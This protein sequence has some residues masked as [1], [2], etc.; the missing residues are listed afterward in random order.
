MARGGWTHSDIAAKFMVG[1]RST[2]IDIDLSQ[3]SIGEDIYDAID[4]EF[5]IKFS[6]MGKYSRDILFIR[7]R[8]IYVTLYSYVTFE[9]LC[10]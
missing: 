8:I 9:F 4:A 1:N 10:I 5:L 6:A 7:V 3:V 2:S